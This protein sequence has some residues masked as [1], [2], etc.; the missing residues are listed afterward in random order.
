MGTS[1]AHQHIPGHDTFATAQDAQAAVDRVRTLHEQIP[2]T[3]PEGEVYPASDP[4]LLTWVHTAEVYFFLHAHH[5]YGA[6]PLGPDAYDEYLADA[7]QVATALG[8]DEP[9]RNRTELR[10]RLDGCLP[11]LRATPPAKDAARFLLREPPLPAVVRLPYSALA[12]GA[13]ELL[14]DRARAR[15]GLRPLSVPGTRV[16]RAGAR[17]VTRTIRGAMT[18]PPSDVGTPRAARPPRQA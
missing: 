5:L 16:P 1:A 18:P 7:A 12:L 6:R 8:A 11:Y 2:G 9:P 13:I 10:Q 4:R 3:T 14:P 15:S 17:T